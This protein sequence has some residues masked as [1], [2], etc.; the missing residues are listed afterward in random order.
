MIE[1]IHKTIRKIKDRFL[2][3][4]WLQISM[5]YHRFNNLRELMQGDLT[6]KVTANV[7]SLDFMPRECNCRNKENCPYLGR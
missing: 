7:K 4:K 2:T 6:T 5:S 3:L 1:A